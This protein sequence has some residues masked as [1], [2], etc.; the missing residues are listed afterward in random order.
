MKNKSR[1]VAL[2]A[3]G[4][5]VLL[6]QSAPSQLKVAQAD[7][8][9]AFDRAF[10]SQYD[11]SVPCVALTKDAMSRTSF[12]W[13]EYLVVSQSAGSCTVE[14]YQG[15]HENSTKSVKIMPWVVHEPCELDPGWSDAE[16]TLTS[17]YGYEAMLYHWV[18]FSGEGEER[19]M[20]WCM[21]VGE[22]LYRFRIETNTASVAD[23]GA[24]DDPLPI[25]E[26]LY[27]LAESYLVEG[28]SA[29]NQPQPAEPSAGMDV[30]PESAD[31]PPAEP[32]GESPPQEDLSTPPTVVVVG[33]IAIPLLGAFLG[34]LIAS[35]SG[36]WGNAVTATIASS[37]APVQTASVSTGSQTTN[38]AGWADR[39]ATPAPPQR[40]PLEPPQPPPSIIQAGSQ[41]QIGSLDSAQPNPTQP[42]S[43]AE[44]I[45]RAPAPSE[46]PPS[47]PVKEQTPSPET[48]QPDIRPLGM[49]FVDFQEEVY[50]Y[51]DELEKKYY[52]ANPWQSDPTVLIHRARCI[53][54]L[55][56][57]KTIGK[58]TGKQGLTCEEYVHKTAQEVAALLKKHIPDA[59]LESVVFEERT[60][61]RFPDKYKE[62]LDWLIEDN[63]NLL[64]VNL[65]D[66][67]Q[68][69]IDFHQNR[70]GRS[71]LFRK[72]DEARQVWKKYMGEDDF[73]ERVSFTLTRKRS[74]NGAKPSP[75]RSSAP[76][77]MGAS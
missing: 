32:S 25:A 59:Y 52:V 11:D 19:G 2:L 57:D 40:A 41:P 16:T 56:Y 54:N 34:A 1:L 33:S 70:A 22:N 14:F 61:M 77:A 17:Y 51:R 50:A 23:Y 48:S 7:S 74:E 37:A 21:P 13:D 6:W 18:P 27:L 29:G 66:G 75:I 55:V 5:W 38:V 47:P 26:A 9:S 36:V 53:Y 60:S 64:R 4:F 58:V 46:K 65:P 8:L 71:P 62:R 24:A 73:V 69:A 42:P 30:P 45:P 76:P 39:L 3:V 72:F 10:Q 44:P 67:T 20:I 35:F 63:H 28:Y 31:M 68:W 43:S 49:R 12:R 15:N